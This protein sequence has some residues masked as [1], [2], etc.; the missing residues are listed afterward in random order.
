M[1]ESSTRQASIRRYIRCDAAQVRAYSQ[2]VVSE[3]GRIVWLAGPSTYPDSRSETGFAD[4]VSR[5]SLLRRKDIPTERGSV[6]HH[7]CREVMIV[8]GTQCR[9]FARIEHC[10]VRS[11]LAANN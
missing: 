8:I 11:P 5:S 7:L 6:Q 3:G 2:A 4:V 9:R 1:I 10:V